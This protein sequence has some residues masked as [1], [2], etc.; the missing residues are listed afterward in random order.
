MN[1]LFQG[2]QGYTLLDLFSA[3]READL[4]FICMVNQRHW[5]L[6]NVF[7]D[8][9]NLPVFW[10]TVMPQLSIEERL[11]LFELI[12]PVHRLLDFWCGQSG[13]TEPWQMPQTWTLRDWETVRVQ[14]HPQLL[15]ANV[16]TGLLEAIR[17]QRSFELSQ[18]LSAPVT[19]PVSLSP[20]LAACLLPLWDAPQS[21]PALVQRALKVRSRDPI[22]LK[23]VNPHQASQEL[24]DALVNLELDLYVLLIRSGKP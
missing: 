7:Q 5:E 20:Y 14:V 11:Q 6:R 1:F 17:Q 19:G 24:Q 21:F 16:K 2:D 23:P 4:E 9:Q 8:P 10:Q 22:T 18:H 13:Q 12:A 3:L 15:T